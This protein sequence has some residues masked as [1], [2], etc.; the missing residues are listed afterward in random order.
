MTA[1]TPTPLPT[2]AAAALPGTWKLVAGRAITLQPSQH[3]V[4]RVAHGRLWATFDGPHGGPLN[5]LGDHVV[6]VGDTVRV[7]AGRRVVIEAWTCGHAAYFTWDP[8]PATAPVRRLAFNDL[9]QPLA[10]L[11]AAARL[12]ARAGTRVVVVLARLVREALWPRR[13]WPAGRAFEAHCK[14]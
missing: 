13:T 10:D 7:A 6:E 9:L 11:R 1:P 5:D 3:G 4:L 14:A 2:S 12:G 8:V